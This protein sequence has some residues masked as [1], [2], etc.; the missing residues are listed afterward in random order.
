TITQQQS[1]GWRTYHSIQVALTRRLRNGFAFG[2]NDTIQLSDK[3]LV[4]LR[5]Q[6]NDN[7]TITV[8]DDQGLA[9]ELLGDNHPLP[10]VM[11]ANFTWDLP[12]YKQSGRVNR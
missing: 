10:H 1:T 3:Q 7:G 12:D 8:R 6:H 2:F 9:Q 11:R 4:P 5:L